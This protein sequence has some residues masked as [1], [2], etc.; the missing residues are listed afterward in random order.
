[1][2]GTTIEVFG[3]KALI[4]NLSDFGAEVQYK[5]AQSMVAYGAGL[6]KKEVQRRC[7][8]DTGT[9]KK[10]IAVRKQSGK[11]AK[12]VIYYVTNTGK[13]WYAHIVEFGSI[14]HPGGYE[15]K[16]R[17][18]KGKKVMSGW[19]T[20]GRSGGQIWDEVYGTKYIHPALKAQ[21]FFRPGFDENRITVLNK[22]KV[23]LGRAVMRYRKKYA[24]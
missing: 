7:P 21:P 22:M 9:L 11:W 17:P 5:T 20:A 18:S 10:S 14:R 3:V 24:A 19:N 4:D 16:L 6:F 2:V 12:D 8:I 13:G 15:I 23:Q 1:M